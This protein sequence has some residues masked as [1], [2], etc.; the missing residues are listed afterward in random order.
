[1]KNILKITIVMLSTLSFGLAQAG[2]LTVTGSVKSTYAITSS[3]STASS[4]EAG[5]GLGVENDFTFGASGENDFGTWAYA[6]DFDGGT[7][8][9]DSKVTLTTS[10]GT[11]GVF[12]SEGGLDTDNAAS[13]SV[14]SRP[15]DTS[16]NEGMWDT[17]DLSASNTLQYHMPKDMLPFG[18]VPK[19]SFAPANS[20]ASAVNDANSGGSTNTGGFTTTTSGFNTTAAIFGQTAQMGRSA[21]HYQVKANPMTGLKMGAD[22]VDFKDVVATNIANTTL[23]QKPESGNAYVTYE[24]GNASLG[25][26]RSATAFAIG[27]VNSNI[28]EDVTGQKMSIAYNVNDALS[29]SYEEEESDMNLTDGATVQMTAK[30][31]QAAYTMGGMTMAIAQ[32]EYENA[33]YTAATDVV[34]TVFSVAM[35]F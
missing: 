31:I 14:Y 27:S 24:I 17:F 16:Y 10:Y 18:I 9:D 4:Q 30:G 32:N 8:L 35:D 6:T 11:F 15:S 25:Y 26:S 12:V 13:Q 21:L 3:D 23:Q 33:R 28:V 2:E 22:Y 5:K 1:M 29:V 34:S 19:V 7:A 20:S